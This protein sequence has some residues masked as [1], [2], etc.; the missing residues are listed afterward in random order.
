M[1]RLTGDLKDWKS[2]SLSIKKL[3]EAIAKL[4]LENDSIQK[5]E[6]KILGM[7]PSQFTSLELWD[8]WEKENIKSIEADK[9]K[10][11]KKKL[12]RPISTV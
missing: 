3:E 11:I 6:N 12:Y 7:I 2:L 5:E 8:A 4:K 10:Y 9:A 1:A